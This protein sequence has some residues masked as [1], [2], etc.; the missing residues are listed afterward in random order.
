MSTEP[1][2]SITARGAKF[3]EAII[4]SVALLAHQL[5]L[6]LLGHLGVEVDEAAVEVGGL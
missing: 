4:S 2:A 3:S 1:W 5:T 6:D